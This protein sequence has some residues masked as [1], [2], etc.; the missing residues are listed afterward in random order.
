MNEAI[1]L[2]KKVG[3]QRGINEAC[4]TIR[5]KFENTDFD[6]VSE[7]KIA[8]YETLVNILTNSDKTEEAE[9]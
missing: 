3:Y 9:S 4:R 2:A 8:L 6:N 5:E 7:M 1:N